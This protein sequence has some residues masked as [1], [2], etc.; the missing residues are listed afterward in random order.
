V[1]EGE[2]ANANQSLLSKTVFSVQN[3]WVT[4]YICPYQFLVLHP[5]LLQMKLLT[6]L[7]TKAGIAITLIKL[8]T[9]LPM[10]IREQ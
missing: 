9:F 1:E 10:V 5:L 3:S 2:V 6:M 8:K 4:C 7:F